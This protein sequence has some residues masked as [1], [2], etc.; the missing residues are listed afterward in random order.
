MKPTIKDVSMAAGVSP[1]TV[2]R[3]LRGSNLVN[4]ETKEKVQNAIAHLGYKYERTNKTAITNSKNVVLVITG[5]TSSTFFLQFYHALKIG[6]HQLGYIPL[7]AYSEYDNTVDEDYLLY[8]EKQK[9]AGVILVTP[10]DS[11]RMQ[12]LLSAH[13][14]PIIL[15]NRPLRAVDL[16][17]IC[18]D[19][20][21]A[22]YMGAQ[23]LIKNGH[24]KIAC[25]MGTPKSS[26]DVEKLTGIQ[27]AFQDAGLDF[28]QAVIL[29]G[30]YSSS[31][32]YNACLA[33]KELLM[34]CTAVF[35]SNEQ[36]THSFINLQRQWGNQV[37]EDISIVSVASVPIT[38]N[39]LDVTT[40]T[41]NAEALGESAATQLG[42][43]LQDSSA[44]PQKIYFPP[45]LHSGN[46][47]SYP[48]F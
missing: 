23:Q 7:I 32:A 24:K 11:P 13:A 37:P 35:I 16:N 5:D 29:Y 39:D 12:T 47:I 8:A 9:F 40:I 45:E 10:T 43:L 3:V 20:Y 38:N 17:V 44:L 22:G 15:V 25:L 2:S 41:Q 1:A 36:M 28:S 46:S 14:I 48:K 19:H 4:D 6:L 21:R 42:H 18:L 30:N 26:A 34:A 27:D 33:Q 31:G